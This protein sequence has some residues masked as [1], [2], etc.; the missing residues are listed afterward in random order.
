M[1]ALDGLDWRSWTAA[2]QSSVIFQLLKRAYKR[3]GDTTGL[4]ELLVM[5][6]DN[7]GVA[8]LDRQLMGQSPS[9]E[10]TL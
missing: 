1:F 9:I 5:V 3:A 6:G 7:A 2:D 10:T 4:R 8:E